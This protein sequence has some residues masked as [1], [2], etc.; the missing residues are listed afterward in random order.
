MGEIFSNLGKFFIV[1]GVVFILIGVFIVFAPKIPYL[2][3]LPGDVYIKKGNFIFY[4]P[5][6]TS[7][8]IS[9]LLTLIFTL[10]SKR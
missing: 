2:G 7:I 3:K 8:L 10:F 9:I 6:A 4:M 1:I 5:L